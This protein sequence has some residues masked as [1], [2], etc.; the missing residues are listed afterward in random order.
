MTTQAEAGR[1]LPRVLGFADVV[2]LYAVAI[3]AMQ[4][5]STA[6]QAG[7]SSL[8]LWV[9]ALV[10]FLIPRLSI[11]FALMPPERGSVPM[12]YAKVISGCIVF[13]GIGLAFY[14]ARREAAQPAD[15]ARK[16]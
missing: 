9:L 13:L 3:V 16:A 11:V 14:C 8:A 4:W 5:L 2:L 7:M 6:A 12:F 10:V 15:D 1:E